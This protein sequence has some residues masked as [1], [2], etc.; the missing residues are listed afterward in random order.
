MPTGPPGSPTTRHYQH[1]QR[2]NPIEVDEAYANIRQGRKRKHEPSPSPDEP[3]SQLR[4]Q[5][6]Q[7]LGGGMMEVAEL[8]MGSPMKEE[9]EA[10]MESPRNKGKAVDTDVNHPRNSDVLK[11][12]A[13]SGPVEADETKM[14]LPQD[15][16]KSV[17]IREMRPWVEQPGDRRPSG[18]WKPG[19]SSNHHL[20]STPSS[21]TTPL[22]ADNKPYVEQPG[23]RR[24]SGAWK[25][26]KGP[27]RRFETTPTETTTTT[28][29]NVTI[30]KSTGYIEPDPDYMMADDNNGED[31]DY[32]D[33][34]LEGFDRRRLFL[35][36]QPGPDGLR[37]IVLGGG[38]T[39][40]YRTAAEAALRCGNL[41]RNRI[42]MRRRPGMKGKKK[43][44]NEAGAPET[45]PVLSASGSPPMPT[46]RALPDL[47]LSFDY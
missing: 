16:G 18:L 25:P 44:E 30:V 12:L 13:M 35:R 32:P 1:H 22:V 5:Q 46:P 7:R 9:D 11:W 10:Y 43:K 36:S 37:R 39:L 23:D 31:V 27:H 38:M 4:L 8:E 26:G 3:G 41:V 33:M 19:N 2:R 14:D 20:D 24:P 21:S 34:P 42:R 6:E 28:Q 29:G 17:D 40:E 15:K 45:S 47:D